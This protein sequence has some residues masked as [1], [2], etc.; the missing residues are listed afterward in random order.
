MYLTPFFF[1]QKAKLMVGYDQ[2]Q[3]DTLDYCMMI[4]LNERKKFTREIQFSPPNA[5]LMIN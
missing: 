2:K 1:S 3:D 5:K 4:L